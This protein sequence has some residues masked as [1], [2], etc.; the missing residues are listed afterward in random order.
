MITKLFS[1]IFGTRNSRIVNNYKKVVNDISLNYEH[2][3][4]LEPTSYKEVINEL[5]LEYQKTKN[6]LGLLPKAYALVQLAAEHSIGLKHFD[7]QLLGGIAL[8]NGKISEM[9]TG[10]GKTLVATLPAVLNSLTGEPVHIVTVND[11][12]AER[13]CSWMSPVYELLGLS[14]SFLKNEFSFEEKKNAYLSDIVYG[15]NNE[16]GFD[17]LRDNMARTRDGMVQRGL[18]FCIVDEVDSVLIDEARTPLVISGVDHDSPNLYKSTDLVV[19]GLDATCYEVDVKA[20][21]VILTESG[22]ARVEK[23]LASNS[24]LPEG[25]DLYS[26][27]YAQIMH[28]ITASLKAHHLFNKDVHYL[29][30]GDEVNIVDEHT[31]RVMQGRRWSDGIHQAIEA[32]EMVSIKPESITLA[33]ITYQ[34]LFRLYSKLSGMTGTAFTESLEFQEIYGLE[35]LIIPPNRTSLRIDHADVIYANKEDKYLAIINEVQ[36]YNKQQRPVLVGTSSIES[37]EELSVLLSK[38]NIKHN[39]LNAKHHEKEA[40]IIAEAGRIGAVTIATNMAGRGTD[41]VLGGS[42]DSFTPEQW[43]EQNNLVKELGG[44]HI[45]GTERHESRR[46]DNQLRG[47]SGRQGDQGSSKFFLSLDDRLMKIFVSDN[48]KKLMSRLG[49]SREEPITH[50]Y[51]SKAVENAQKKV[52]GHNFDIR[53]QLLE[54]D[55]IANEQRKIIYSQRKEIL[56]SD[57]I[58]IVARELL[59]D[60]VLLQLDEYYKVPDRK[61]T[62]TSY[63]EDYTLI[64]GLSIAETDEQIVKDVA[65][66]IYKKTVRKIPD[67]LEP[68]MVFSDIIISIIDNKWQ[69]HLSTL[70]YIRQSIHLKGYGQKDPK[71]EYKIESFNMFN[72]M[73]EWIKVEFT[74]TL[75]HL[76]IKNN[77]EQ[78]EQSINKQITDDIP[79]NALC[80]CNSGLKYKHCHGKIKI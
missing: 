33:S 46:I 36:T 47:R 40:Q 10:E 4:S 67:G 19:R 35:V 26:G 25:A 24:L 49:L 29:V 73:L 13:D 51:I 41:I 9:G 54:F 57:S 78:Q 3:K 18:G 53:K 62:L 60:A 64:E 37:S 68:N 45:I 69:E 39:V 44:L 5:K 23:L 56:F 55:N 22:I 11:Y 43:V 70:D 20:N 16:F 31:G 2:L 21:N 14:V 61:Q 79:K 48:I 7:V 59:E 6:L 15:A 42:K 66:A 58:G 27:E 1:A 63:L 71:N 17:Y 74:N 80:P 28:H 32:K 38:K 75:I 76:E 50:N 12:L 65:D 52:E 72:K 34:N 30:R 8:A 77:P